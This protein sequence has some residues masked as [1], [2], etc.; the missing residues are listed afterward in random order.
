MHHTYSTLFKT[1]PLHVLER[2]M[3]KLVSLK[4]SLYTTPFVVCSK[5]RYTC[6]LVMFAKLKKFTAEYR[7]SKVK[8]ST[9]TKYVNS[10]HY[11]F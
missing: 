1:A 2:R 8:D 4:K 10:L 3:N 6:K 9:E 11:I 5:V 7:I